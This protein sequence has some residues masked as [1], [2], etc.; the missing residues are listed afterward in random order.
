MKKLIA[1]FAATAAFALGQIGDTTAV[2]A[3]VPLL[4]PARLRSSP[5]VIVEAAGALG[6]LRTAA[7]RP[8]R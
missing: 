5:T 6:K 1:A 8:I 4:D 2:A 7:A 3:L